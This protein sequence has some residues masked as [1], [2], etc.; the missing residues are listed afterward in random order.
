M[1]ISTLFLIKRIKT[2]IPQSNIADMFSLNIQKC[3]FGTSITEI[4][5]YTFNKI[6][7]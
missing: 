3:L 2:S 5:I 1:V 4:Y 7:K 6:R